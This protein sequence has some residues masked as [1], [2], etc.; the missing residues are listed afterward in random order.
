MRQVSTSCSVAAS[1][2]SVYV[3]ASIVQLSQYKK[4]DEVLYP[5]YTRFRVVNR[6]D[7]S[8]PPLGCTPRVSCNNTLLRRVLRR[9]SNSKCFLVGFLEG[10]CKGFSVKTRFLKGF[11]EGSFL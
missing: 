5:P 1:S 11:F 10:A 7:R 9:L 8:A 6:I 2:D 3:P 4:E